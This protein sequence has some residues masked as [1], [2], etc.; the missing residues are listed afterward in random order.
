MKRV[1]A[2]VVPIPTDLVSDLIL[3]QTDRA[4]PRRYS[5]ILHRF[6]VV[7][8]TFVFALAAGGGAVIP[9]VDIALGVFV[10]MMLLERTC[11]F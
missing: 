9:K 2:F 3:R 6:L 11:G 10:P 5:G 4:D 7:G 8:T 1:H